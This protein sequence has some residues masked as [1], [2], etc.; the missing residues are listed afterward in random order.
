MTRGAFWREEQIKTTTPVSRTPCNYG[1]PRYHQ[2]KGYPHATPMATRRRLPVHLG[3]STGDLPPCHETPLRRKTKAPWRKLIQS[4]RAPATRKDLGKGLAKKRPQNYFSP[5]CIRW[6][7]SG[8]KGDAT[9]VNLSAQWYTLKKLGAAQLNY[10][11]RE[12]AMLQFVE[13]NWLTLVSILIGVLVAFF[14][15]RLQ[16]KDSVSAS[17]ERKKH[18]SR[19]LLDVVESYVINKQ[20]LSEQVVENLIAA[21]ERD[22]QVLLREACTPISLLQDVALRLQRSRHLDI[23]QKSEYSLKI[24]TLIKQIRTS[25]EV[26]ALDQLNK[27]FRDSLAMVQSLVPEEKRAEAKKAID[28]IALLSERRRD[29]SAKR[30]GDESFVQFVVAPLAAG[31]ATSFVAA[32]LGS[33]LLSDGA[34]TVAL[35]AAGKMLPVFG[36]LVLALILVGVVIIIMR[37][38]RRERDIK[39][40]GLAEFP[41]G[42][43][44]RIF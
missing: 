31:L 17:V 32:S 38:R 1:F 24:D 8:R 29:L 35:I 2:P 18:A 41:A 26:P 15:Y 44:H 28:A 30:S 21:S 5:C 39:K 12:G 7:K 42:S 25:K 4:V 11:P 34:L 37:I 14:F 20:D 3:P 13:T 19:E 9:R 36:F 16:K 6:S 10:M 33:S 43:D 27:D 23:P 40:A 22:Y